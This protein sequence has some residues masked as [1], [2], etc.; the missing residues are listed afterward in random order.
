MKPE[1]SDMLRDAK[2][3]APSPRYSVDDFVAAGR[4]RQ[5]KTRAMWAGTGTAAAVLA[6][7]GAVAVPQLLPGG[8]ADDAPATQ[9]AAPAAEKKPFT[10]PAGDFT[11]NIKPYRVGDLNV[12]AA[13]QVTSAY[14]I[15]SI[16]GPG[17]GQV[18]EDE[19]GTQRDIGNQVAALVV[20]RP[21][22]F[23]PSAVKK[24]KQ[25]GEA[26][27]AAG[28]AGDPKKGKAGEDGFYSWEYADDSWAVIKFQ[29]GQ[30][31]AA[32]DLAEVAEGLTAAE[33]KPVQIGFKLGYVPAGFA[34]NAA[35]TTWDGMAIPLEGGS[36]AS[37]LKGDFPYSGL[38]DTV[39]EPYLV[40][41]KQLPVLT[42]QVVPN[43]YNKHPAAGDEPYCASAGLCYVQA[44][45]GKVTLELN[46]GGF[47]PDAELKKV[48]GKV[49]FASGKAWFDATAA[50][51]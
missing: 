5:R 37:L 47:L 25:V 36:Y 4:K 19:D 29:G 45:G 40:G 23:D 15:A 13:T 11:A 33:E 28:V 34:L 46:G 12:S 41:D 17:R 2:S 48:L 44:P 14:E 18:F 22:T 39:H 31:L 16:T 10:Y 42:L 49:T 32:S 38:T 26:F 9:V 50:I 3:D 6:V 35:G 51:K 21:G 7:A 30:K 1:L 43:W 20:Y 27:Y 24:G 8:E